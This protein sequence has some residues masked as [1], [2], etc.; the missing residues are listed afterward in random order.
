MQP[1]RER[2]PDKIADYRL[3][4]R[5]GEGGM[6][7]VYLARSSRGRVVAVKTIRSELAATPDFRRRAGGDRHRPLRPPPDRHA[8]GQTQRPTC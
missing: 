4:G 6:G 5:L 7:V 3:I 1:L 8:G 2:D